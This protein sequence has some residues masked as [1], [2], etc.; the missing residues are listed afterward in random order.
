MG[1]Y[2]TMRQPFELIEFHDED[3]PF[4]MFFEGP[5]SDQ[6]IRDKFEEI[7]RYVDEFRDLKKVLPPPR[8]TSAHIEYLIDLLTEG[9]NGLPLSSTLKP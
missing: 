8:E 6:V 9:K 2:L 4:M 7:G 5:E 3:E 1:P